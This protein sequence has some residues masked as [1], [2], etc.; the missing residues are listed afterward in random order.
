M[1]NSKV[2]SKIYKLKGII[3]SMGLMAEMNGDYEHPLLDSLTENINEI[4][5]ELETENIA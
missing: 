1:K 3:E 5:E 2:T 4:I